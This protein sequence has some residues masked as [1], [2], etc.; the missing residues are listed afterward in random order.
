[1]AIRRL[2]ACAAAIE[3]A[4]GL[5]LMVSPPFVSQLLLGDRVTGPGMAV[6]RVGGVALLSLGLACWPSGKAGALRT[7]GHRALL[8]YN[9]LVALYLLGLGIQGELVGKLLWPAFALHAVLTVLLARAWFSN[10]WLSS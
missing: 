4:T 5:A 9:L 1:M 7:P 10:L 8:T 3:G 6:G 2:L